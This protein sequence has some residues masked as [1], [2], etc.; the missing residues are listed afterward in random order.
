MVASSRTGTAA[1]RP[2]VVRTLGVRPEGGWS[3]SS[4][5]VR[6]VRWRTGATIGTEGWTG[7]RT[8]AGR[9]AAFGRGRGR[10]VTEIPMALAAAAISRTAAEPDSGR[11]AGSFSSRCRMTSASGSGTKSG[12]GGTGS[13]TCENAMSTCVSPVKGRRPAAAS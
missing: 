7:V 10:G 13:L 2:V 6:R 12:S 3:M 4:G 1:W 11:F 5:S 8:S 9:C